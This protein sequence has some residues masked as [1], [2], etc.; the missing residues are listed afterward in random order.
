MLPS[1]LTAP[2]LA[3]M[4]RPST[5]DFSNSTDISRHGHWITAEQVGR[6]FQEG[7]R[8]HLGDTRNF[9][10]TRKI[11]VNSIE[12][13]ASAKDV[14]EKVTGGEIV[15]RETNEFSAGSIH[16]K[17]DVWLALEPSVLVLTT[18]VSGY[19]IPF[20]SSPTKPPTTQNRTSALKHSSFVTSEIAGLLK[21]G[22][23]RRVSDHN[24]SHVLIHPL[25]VA[26]GKKLRLVLDLSH[27]NKFVDVP[28]FKLDDLSKILHV[29]PYHG[30]MT[31]FDLRSG[32]HHLRVCEEHSNYLGFQWQGTLF[33]FVVL[34]FGLSSAP[35]IFTKMLRPFIKK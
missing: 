16:H 26:I 12:E 4:A 28:K 7:T 17:R 35:H 21:S 14:E 22:S 29:L 31:T 13:R 15:R 11:N 18:I 30:Y 6:S 33:Q 8:H 20:L 27:L 2:S 23:I 32:Y 10:P 34:P 9:V 19:S 24:I 1:D 3:T 5:I 25:S